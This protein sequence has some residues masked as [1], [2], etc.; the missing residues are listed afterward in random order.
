MTSQAVL[1][2]NER[3]KVI[4]TGMNDLEKFRSIGTMFNYYKIHG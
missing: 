2:T 1:I 3:S 4:G